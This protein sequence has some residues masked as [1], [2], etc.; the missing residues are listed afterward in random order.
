MSDPTPLPPRPPRMPRLRPLPG[1]VVAEVP[2]R[3]PFHDVDMM[4][5]AWHGNY[6]KY[7]ELARTELE[8][9]MGLT[10]EVVKAMGLVCPVVDAHC[11]Y[12][13]PLRNGDEARVR[14]FI[15]D[16][17]RSLMLGYEILNDTA[18]RKSAEGYTLQVGL[19]ASTFELVLELPDEIVDRARDAAGLPRLRGGG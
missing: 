19:D 11:R 2:F 4:A 15:V 16:A 17:D 10:H 12:L 18:R 9:R 5:V 1:A 13:F 8:R 7:F 6:L 14:C 3:V